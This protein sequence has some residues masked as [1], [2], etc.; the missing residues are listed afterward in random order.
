M[1]DPTH[2]EWHR[3]FNA[4]LNGTLRA[5]ERPQLAELLK[6]SAEARQLWYLYHDNEC[7]LSELKLSAPPIAA[8]QGMWAPDSALAPQQTSPWLQWRSLAAAAAGLVIGLFG[9]TVVYGL[10]VHRGAEK[11]TPLALFEPGFENAQLPLVKGIPRGAG[12]WGGDAAQV[13]AGEN[14]V[15][16]KEGRFMLR[17]QPPA[18]GAWRL[19]QVLDLQTLPPGGSGESREIEISAALATVDA[20][21]SVRFFIRAFAVTEAPDEMDAA[22]LDRRD[23]SIASATRGVDL[24]PGTQ[25]WQTLGVTMQVPRNARSLVLFLGVRTP[26][27]SARESPMYLDDVRVTLVTPPWP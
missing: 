16:T 12:R 5:A 25:G 4:A 10:A 27:K 11:K 19:Y 26:D 15:P 14:G 6:S 9:A 1:N 3:L 21:A 8:R 13:V 20:D 2:R 17:L 22:W 23:E 18:R 24:P 7:G